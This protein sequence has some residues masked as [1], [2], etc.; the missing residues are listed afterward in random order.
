MSEKLKINCGGFYLDNETI[1]EENGM[2]KVIGGGGTDLPEYTADDIGK[3]L[4]VVTE[5]SHTETETFVIVQEQTVS[6]DSSD[7]CY[8]LLPNT[9]DFSNLIVGES[10]EWN[11]N[12]SYGTAIVEPS[13]ESDL[14]IFLILDPSH[15][16]G[17]YVHLDETNGFI[18]TNLPYPP[19]SIT[20]SI[21]KTTETVIREPG[22]AWAAPSSGGVLIVHADMDTWTLDKTWQE[23]YDA[24]F[25]VLQVGDQFAWLLAIGE[26]GG[27]F[28]VAYFVYG[29]E[30]PTEFVVDS[31]NGYPTMSSKP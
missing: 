6:F 8:Y 29:E 23:I 9:Y 12:N 20:L 13:T 14:V 26:D 7:D 1:T 3:S 15:R 22:I 31:A 2:L 21:T 28:Y 27:Y 24:G 10:V 25:S 16:Y 30:N 4:T 5:S 19:A 17:Y 18:T 11:V